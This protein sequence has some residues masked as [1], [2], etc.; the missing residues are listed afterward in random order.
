MAKKKA[1]PKKTDAGKRTTKKTAAGSQKQATIK[2]PPAPAVLHS[3]EVGAPLAQDRAIAE[4]LR[5]YPRATVQEI[6]AMFELDGMQVTP[7]AV[8]KA[9]SMIGGRQ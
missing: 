2:P 3:A 4:K 1:A 9:K 7:A 8:R 5:L 6:V